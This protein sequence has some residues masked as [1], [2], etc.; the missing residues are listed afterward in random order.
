MQSHVPKFLQ[1]FN[2]IVFEI[3]CLRQFG[4]IMA[5]TICKSQ[6]EMKGQRNFGMSLGKQG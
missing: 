1:A 6:R 4:P 5:G 2:K 3:G